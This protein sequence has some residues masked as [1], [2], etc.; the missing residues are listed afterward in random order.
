MAQSFRVSS[1]FFADLQ[2]PV[3]SAIQRFESVGP[4]SGALRG[5]KIVNRKFPEKKEIP[6]GPRD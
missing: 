5:S 3:G 1:I 6:S 4:V 2:D